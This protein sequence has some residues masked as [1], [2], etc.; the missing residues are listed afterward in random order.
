[1][2]STP[3]SASTWTIMSAPFIVVP[4]S[5]CFVA[6]SAAVA[7]RR[8][9]RPMV[10]RCRSVVLE[11]APRVQPERVAHERRMD[12]VSQERLHARRERARRLLRN[13]QRVV[14]LLSCPRLAILVRK[15][16]PCGAAAI[17][18]AAVDECA[19]EHD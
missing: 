1:M 2:V 7:R 3:S 8:R 17:R 16:Q 10:S 11:D 4:A 6:A 15:R 5:G 14:L 12:A 18:A 19:E 13:R 9:M